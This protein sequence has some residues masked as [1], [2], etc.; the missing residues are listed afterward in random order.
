M[1][2]HSLKPPPRERATFAPYVNQTKPTNQRDGSGASPTKKSPLF[3]TYAV[4]YRGG[5]GGGGDA[6]NFRMYQW[7]NVSFFF[8]IATFNNKCVGQNLLDQ[9]VTPVMAVRIMTP[10][11]QRLRPINPAAYPQWSTP[12]QQHPP[13]T[14]ET[15]T[16]PPYPHYHHA[17]H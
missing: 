17:Y 8:F 16:P 15:T 7:A 5:R 11:K 14:P 6:R 13:A 10:V 9:P 4:H 3:N 1:K 12:L 2:Y